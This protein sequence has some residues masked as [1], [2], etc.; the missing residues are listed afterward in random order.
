MGDCCPRDLREEAR[1]DLLRGAR[2]R[3]VEAFLLDLT[4]DF[5]LL[6]V[7]AF[8]VPLLFEDDFFAAPTTDEW[9]PNP[10]AATS[11]SVGKKDLK[12]TILL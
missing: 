11:A 10:R 1:D 9:K 5:V 7:W 2:R 4:E 6:A 3:T 12:N 8:A